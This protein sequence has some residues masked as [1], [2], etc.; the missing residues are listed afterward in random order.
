MRKITLALAFVFGA[1]TNPAMA[2]HLQ[3]NAI[4]ES[5]VWKECNTRFN[6]AG[7][8]E[9][10]LAWGMFPDKETKRMVKKVR[11]FEKGRRKERLKYCRR[12]LGTKG[13]R[14]NSCLKQRG[15]AE[16]ILSK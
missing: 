10:L 11:E 4:L 7:F 16:P 8:D 5:D 9:C 15:E 1:L 2:F 6:I 14:M 3:Q 13:F 12:W